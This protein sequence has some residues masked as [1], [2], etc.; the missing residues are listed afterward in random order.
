MV[1]SGLVQQGQRDSHNPCLIVFALQEVLAEQVRVELA[2]TA[3]QVFD[4]DRNP[5]GPGESQ[6]VEAVGLVE[7][8][9]NLFG[10]EFGQAVV[11]WG[12]EVHVVVRVALELRAA[13]ESHAHLRGGVT[14]KK[15]TCE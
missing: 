1:V 8:D 2:I 4:P 15:R 14:Q 11:L 10:H 7:N 9:I 12:H 3:I 6:N 5:D 13:H